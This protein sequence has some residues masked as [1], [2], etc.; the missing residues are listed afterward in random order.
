MNIVWCFL[1]SVEVQVGL[2]ILTNFHME[3]YFWVFSDIVVANE[4][5]LLIR[6]DQSL[7]TSK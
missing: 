4:P 7:E 6:S 1:S 5:F 2:F 3:M